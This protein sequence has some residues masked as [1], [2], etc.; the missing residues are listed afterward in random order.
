[1]AH[2]SPR[3]SARLTPVRCGHSSVGRDAPLL[4]RHASLAL[5]LVLVAADCS[6]E[7]R[8][9]PDTV[10][11]PMVPPG[12][13]ALVDDFGD[14]VPV[15]PAAARIVSLN[16]TTTEILF[17]LG[18][19]ARVVGRTTWDVWPDSARAVPDM[20]DGIRPNVERVLGA[21][22]DL[23]VLYASADNRAAAE[24]FRAAGIRVF[25]AKVDRIA[26]FERVVL[27]L[28][29]LTGT[30]ARARLTRDSVRASL[31]RVRAATSGLA[32]PTVF[33][34]V[35]DQ[36]VITVGA[37][38][39]MTE[40]VET[41]GGRNVY[42]DRPG[43]SVQVAM[44]DVLRRDPEVV[45]AGP[46]GKRRIEGDVAWRALRAVREHRVVVVD[47]NLVGRPSVRLGEAARGLARLLHPDVVLP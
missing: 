23:V 6:R 16:P 41:A 34:H 24:R 15:R 10:H 18:A 47:T 29:R 12:G 26:D 9:T 2:G 40:L 20:G 11:A 28:G 7:A 4:F 37:G 46:Q 33:W 19:G 31:D 32:H 43:V 38:S 3:G 27:D 30:G 45:I 25:A 14:T 22:P 1:M 21:R 17:A 13:G 8:S 39:Y 42:G 35:W 5:S 36:P 44:E